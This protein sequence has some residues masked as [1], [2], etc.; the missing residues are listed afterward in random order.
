[1]NQELTK[2]EYFAALAM[3]NLQNVL[4]RK[5]GTDLLTTLKKLYENVHPGYTPYTIEM[6]I[7]WAAAEQ[8]DALLNELKLRTRG[9]EP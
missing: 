3:Q 6:V 2:R 9:E 8:A 1:M 5:S 7:A 4:W